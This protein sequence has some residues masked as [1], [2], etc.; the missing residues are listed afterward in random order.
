MCGTSN[1]E[2]QLEC[3]RFFAEKSIVLVWLAKNGKPFSSGTSL[4]MV[5]SKVSVQFVCRFDCDYTPTILFFVRLQAAHYATFRLL[6]QWRNLPWQAG[7]RGAAR[8]RREGLQH[9]KLHPRRG[10]AHCSG[11]VWPCQ[12]TEPTA[13]VSGPGKLPRSVSLLEGG[14]FVRKRFLDRLRRWVHMCAEIHQATM[15]RIFR[16]SSHT[17]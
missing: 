7:P 14:G 8:W 12:A 2:I 13:G 10:G 6:V 9:L 11:C 5:V 17:E 1:S 3:R 4:H 16:L 15:F